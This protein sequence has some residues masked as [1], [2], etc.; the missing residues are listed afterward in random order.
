MLSR[1]LIKI[2]TKKKLTISCAESASSGYLS[3]LLT[4]TPGSSQV[5]K[6]G[7]ICYSLESKNK[8][9]KIPTYLLKKSQGV[10]R[11][12][13]YLL[14]KQVKNIL[15]T[16]IGLSIVGFA[17]PNDK[18]TGLFFCGISHKNT[19]IVKKIQLNG[20]RNQIRKKA[21]EMLIELLLTTL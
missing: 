7:I 4:K 9:F 19:T 6:G 15:A 12:I 10:S 18:K 1:K 8:F 2:L 21:S 16:N 11:Q 17:G 14:A 20:N 13:S 3:Y 5:F